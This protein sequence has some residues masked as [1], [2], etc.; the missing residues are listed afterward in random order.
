M[1]FKNSIFILLWGSIMMGLIFLSQKD[2]FFY[3]NLERPLNK[4]NISDIVGNILSQQGEVLVR[5]AG[6]LL[7]RPLDAGEKVREDT[8]YYTGS[9]SYLKL[10]I[11]DV[12]ELDILEN[13]I[14]GLGKFNV[15][16]RII[17]STGEVKIKSADGIKDE[18]PAFTLND[19]LKEVTLKAT[20]NQ[21]G[22]RETLETQSTIANYK[23]DASLRNSKKL[24]RQ[25]KG[26]NSSEYKQNLD[27]EFLSNS[28]VKILLGLYLLIFIF[29]IRQESKGR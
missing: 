15:K 13:T 9:H 27:T 2:Y 18:I 7:W 3:I 29:M 14:F 17:L 22:A 20:K 5:E 23:M 24:I 16:N 6:E 10:N 21:V 19:G 26:K 28:W 1:K 12:M 25:R 8:W 11:A 4:K